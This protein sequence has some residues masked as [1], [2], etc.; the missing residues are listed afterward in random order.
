MIVE[1]SE[2]LGEMYIIILSTDDSQKI[3]V[4]EEQLENKINKMFQKEKENLSFMINNIFEEGLNR[5]NN[6]DRLENNLV[7]ESL[8]TELSVLDNSKLDK[9]N[10]LLLKGYSEKEIER[11]KVFLE[12]KNKAKEKTSQRLIK[13]KEKIKRTINSKR[14]VDKKDFDNFIE[15]LFNEIQEIISCVDQYLEKYKEYK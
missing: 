10:T 5:I 12:E 7:E 9:E 2:L 14:Y 8:L 15:Y 3:E 11:I 1:K 4:S 6:E 13:E